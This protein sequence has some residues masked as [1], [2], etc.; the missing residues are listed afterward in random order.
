MATDPR[1]SKIGLKVWTAQRL[2]SEDIPRPE[3]LLTPWLKERDQWMVYAAPGV[4]K[5]FFVL[6]AAFAVASGGA[7]LMWKSPR[8]KRVLYV[9]GEMESY[10]MQDRLRGIVEA[11]KRNDNGDTV[12]GLTN[13]F[14]WA[15][16]YQAVGKKFPDL[17]K[18][19]GLRALLH[20]VKELRC[21]LV[22]I[23]NLTTTMMSGDPN[24][25]R[26]WTPMQ[27]ALVELRKRGI[28]V[29]LVHHAN[30]LGDQSGTA[31]KDVTL[32][33]KMKLEQTGWAS[34]GA[35]FQI[36]WEKARGLH[37]KDIPPIQATL[38]ADELGLP[39]WEHS[40]LEHRAYE[41]VRLAESGDF[42]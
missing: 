27:N 39:K 1:G 32:N 8:P 7:F 4:G 35:S 17:A 31:A 20:K 6:N 29:I 19:S 33:G 2:L 25:A 26:F 37:G 5:T 30:K 28:A 11:A 13:F 22:V 10:D 15:A 41:L 34:D 42:S 21:D 38:D 24:E 23:D 9:D 14:G 36:S 12:K 40:T 16:T 18:E 3:P